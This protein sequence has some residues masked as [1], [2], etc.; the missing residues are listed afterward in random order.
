MRLIPKAATDTSQARRKIAIDMNGMARLMSLL[1]R[2]NRPGLGRAGPCTLPDGGLDKMA[3]AFTISDL[4][5]SPPVRTT[6]GYGRN[7][8]RI[9]V[10][11][12]RRAGGDAARRSRSHPESGLAA[13]TSPSPDP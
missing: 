11:R 4:A 5:K 8:G 7:I 12:E 2:R 13:P 10:Y 9:R 1:T 3:G 6:R